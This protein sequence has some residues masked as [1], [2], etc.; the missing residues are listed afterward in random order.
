M[1][2]GNL[3]ADV[4]AGVG[5]ELAWEFGLVGSVPETDKIDAIAHLVRKRARRSLLLAAASET[6][7]R[8]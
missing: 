6:S 2:A 1:A 5:A 8:A 4:W 3:A 7:E